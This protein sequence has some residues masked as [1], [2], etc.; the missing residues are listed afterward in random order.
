MLFL[1]K[2][3]CD[4]FSII[5]A[6]GVMLLWFGN[7]YSTAQHAERDALNYKRFS[8]RDF[9]IYFFAIFCFRFFSIL[10]IFPIFR[11]LKNSKKGFPLKFT[12]FENTKELPVTC[13]SFV[14][15]KKQTKRVT[16]IIQTRLCNENKPI[17]NPRFP[18]GNKTGGSASDLPIEA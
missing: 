15:T 11:K 3:S 17:A 6:L 10:E 5:D 18:R 14:W 1:S 2:K 13:I 16:Y 12:L 9:G 7:C 8:L 4:C